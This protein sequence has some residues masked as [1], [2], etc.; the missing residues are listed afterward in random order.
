MNTHQNNNFLLE[1]FLQKKFLYLA[2]ILGVILRLFLINYYYGDYTTYL[3]KWVIILK[4]DGFSAFKNPFHNYTP[5]YIYTLW[6]FSK[7]DISSL[8]LI[9]I[10]SFVFDYLLAFYIGKLAYLST[11]DKRHFWF[12]IAIIPIIPTIFLNSGLMSQ[13]DSIYATFCIMSIY[14]LLTSRHLLSM[15]CLGIAFSLKIQM[16]CIMP[17]FFVY[18][19]R[20]HI[21][22]YLFLIL[23]LVYLI[24]ILPAWLSGASIENLLSVYIKQSESSSLMNVFFPN[25]YTWL[26]ELLQGQMLLAV[27]FTASIIFIGGVILSNKKYTFSLE[28]WIQILFLSVIL[29]PYLL[30]GMR[31]RYMYLGDTIGILY[32]TIFCRQAYLVI[33]IIFVSFYSYVQALHFMSHYDVVNYPTYAFSFFKFIPSEIPSTIYLFCII[34]VLYHLIKLLKGKPTQEEFV[35]F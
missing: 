28:I 9:K 13:C 29:C 30:P 24:S 12:A 25:I 18:M 6:L 16:F 3:S 7:V 1:Y 10:F 23:P 8:Y 31:E 32:L 15:I 20:G 26:G 35:N 4:T 21:K 27:I 2:L 34:G 17:F 22:W 14:Y 33:G 5:L 19:L 11:K